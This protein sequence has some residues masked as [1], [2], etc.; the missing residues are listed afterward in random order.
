[1][2]LSDIRREIDR[3]DSQLLPLFTARMECAK[4]VARIKK[5]EGLPVLNASREEE[6]LGRVSAQA[7]EYGDAARILYSTLMD[8]SRALQHDL[9]G[10]GNALRERIRAAAGGTLPEPQA[11][12]CQGVPGSYSEEAA[13]LLFPHNKPVFY[14]SFEEVFLAVR[15]GKADYGILPVENSSAGSVSD[16]YDLILRHQFYLVGAVDLPIRHCLAAK[17]GVALEEIREVYS[18]PQGLAQCADALHAMGLTAVPYSN[19]AAA[20]ELVSREGGARAAICSERAAR[21][22]DLA[23]LKQDVQDQSGNC[24]RFI[25]IS[26]SLFLSDGADKISLCFSLPHVTGS[27]YRTL[28]RFA[29]GGLNLTKIESRPISGKRFEYLFYLDFTGNV[30]EEKVQNLLCALSDE[31]PCFTF[32]GNYREWSPEQAHKL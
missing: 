24:T 26:R 9:L 30:L 17:P 8:V 29:L 14:K 6:I 3:I 13:S 10:G 7:G 28:A 4:E 22:Y 31:M 21:E 25:V 20:A 19:T 16:V 32:L 1:M 15:D 5:A 27:L 11:L 23:V 2:S 12:A 18:H